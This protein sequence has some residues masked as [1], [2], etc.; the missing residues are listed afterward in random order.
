MDLPLPVASAGK[1]GETCTR[2][3]AWLRCLVS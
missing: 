1:D 2:P 3:L